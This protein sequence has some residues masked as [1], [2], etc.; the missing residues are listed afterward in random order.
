MDQQISVKE[1]AD[2]QGMQGVSRSLVI[3]LA[4]VVV[5]GGFALGF[6]VGT[7][8]STL[9]DIASLVDADTAELNLI[10][11]A[12]LLVTVVGGPILGRLGDRFG[13]LRMLAVALGI[14]ALGGLL[15]ALAS[16]LPA[17]LVGRALQGAVGTVFVLGPALV[18]DR[19]RDTQASKVIAG[20]AGAMYC[21]VIVGTVSAT[22]VGGTDQGTRIALG[23]SAAVFAAA[24][25]LTL[26]APESRERVR[27][28]MD[29]PGAALLAIALG[30]IVFGLRQAEAHSWGDWRALVLFGVGLFTLAFWIR[31]ES[32]SASPLVDVRAISNR[33]VLPP[34]AIAFVFGIAQYGASTAMITF[35]RGNRDELGYGLSLST[36]EFALIFIPSLILAFISALL[37]PR[38]VTLLGTRIAFTL[39]SVVLSTGFALM[40]LYHDSLA[41]FVAGLAL[42]FAGQG[43][44]Q[45]LWPMVL[46]SAAETSGRGAITGVGQSLETLGGGLSSAFFATIMGLLVIN[47][48]MTPTIDAYVW[49]WSICCVVSASIIPVAFVLRAAKSA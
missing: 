36:G 16:T 48:T 19:L 13:H 10:V 21:G 24:A 47:G 45:A 6:G 37:T 23:I 40:V 29:L 33:R 42:Q 8:A 20:C 3:R 9:S 26:I 15:V 41:F 7:L 31:F 25:A 18:R 12:Q 32:R 39:G 14:T 44:L 11:T 34:A 1:S 38:L 4:A 46:S 22:V 30:S 2:G 27:S 43:A 5:A 17:L 49:I 28:G 35:A